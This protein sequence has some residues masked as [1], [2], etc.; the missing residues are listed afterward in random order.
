MQNVS[1]LDV[2]W[3][4]DTSDRKS[5]SGYSFYFEGSLV[6]WSA[7][8]QKSIALSSTEAEYYVMTHAFKEALWLCS[9]LLWNILIFVITSYAI[10]FP[11]DLFQLLGYLQK[12]CLRTFS[13]RPFLFQHSLAIV[14][15]LVCS[16]LLLFLNHFILF[17][18]YEF[19]F[20]PFW[21]GCVGLFRTSFTAC[22]SRDYVL[23]ISSHF[24]LIHSSVVNL[25]IQHGG[26][27]FIH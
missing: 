23:P 6:S 19:C 14:M 10:I 9:F 25:F 4:S 5:I 12:I 8:K 21:W 2:D 22:D 13:R 1:C 11:M 3:A 15:F 24:T 18:S 16:F 26:G 27:M 20:F 7:V 17:L